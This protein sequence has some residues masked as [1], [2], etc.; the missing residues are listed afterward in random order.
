MPEN[1]VISSEMNTLFVY[2]TLRPNQPN[3]HILA[4]LGGRWQ[5]GY[6]HG[7]VHTLDWG[8]D[9]GLPAIVLDPIAAQVEGL[10]FI[11]DQLDA[12][13]P[14]LDEFEGLQYQRVKVQGFDDN[15]HCVDAWVYIMK[16]L[17]D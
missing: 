14:M 5:K 8:P 15:G 3:E 16:N 1:L 7:I 12:H 10:F 2:G 13:L 17:H 6:V 11:H 9:I 4:P